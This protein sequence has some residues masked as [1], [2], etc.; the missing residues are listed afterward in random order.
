MVR[1]KDFLYVCEETGTPTCE[2][3]TLLRMVY[4]V[5]KPNVIVDVNEIQRKMEKITLLSCGN[6]FH[7]LSTKLEELQQEIN[8]EM[9]KYGRTE[10]VATRKCVAGKEKDMRA[11][12][13][14]CTCPS[15][16]WISSDVICSLGYRVT[17]YPRTI[18]LY[19]Y[20]SYNLTIC[21]LSG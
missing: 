17:P 14:W 2:G 7:V 12:S 9:R 21:S 4:Q 19:V 20:Y 18:Q 11:G 5:V 10:G 16:I 3:F 13:A 8:A 6:D 15:P 1:K